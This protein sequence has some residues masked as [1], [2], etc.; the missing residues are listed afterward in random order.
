MQSRRPHVECA[1]SLD[2]DMPDLHRS[3][4]HGPGPAVENQAA[5]DPVPENAEQRGVRRPAPSLTSASVATCTSL[6]TRTCGPSAALRV[7]ASGNVPL[8][9]G[10][11]RG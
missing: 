9:A 3:T 10:Q 5:A 7:A 6:P 8:P 1:P 11:T 2:D 4:A